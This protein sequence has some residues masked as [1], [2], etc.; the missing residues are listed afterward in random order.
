MPVPDF[1]GGYRI[2]PDEV[3]FWAGRPNRLHDRLVF[4]RT[5]EGD[6]GDLFPSLFF[7]F[8]FYHLLSQTAHRSASAPEPL[9]ARGAPCAAPPAR[10]A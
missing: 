8:F 2:V 4:A 10:V 6:L 9:R 3:E 7:F 5:D 1:W